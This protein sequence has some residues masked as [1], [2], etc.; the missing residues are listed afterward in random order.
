MNYW[1]V[2]A[3]WGTDNLAEAFYRRGY[4]EMGYDDADKPCFATRRNRIQPGDRIAVKTRDGRG[5]STIC[6]KAI[7]VVKE[8]VEGKVYI[9]WILKSIDRHVPSKNYFG[10]IHGPLK[11]DDAWVWQAFC[12]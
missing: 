2:G 4:W 7:G 6:I 3:I 11:S 9:D 1:V 5:A 8:V 12:I 10:T